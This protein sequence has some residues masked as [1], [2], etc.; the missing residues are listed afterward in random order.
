MQLRKQLF[1]S[2][3]HYHCYFCAQVDILTLIPITA[4]H[5]KHKLIII[6]LWLIRLFDKI[7]NN[8]I[9]NQER[10]KYAIVNSIKFSRHWYHTPT[11]ISSLLV[12]QVRAIDRAGE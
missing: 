10:F 12:L 3:L 1:N 8:L 11:P 6:W 2:P 7:N 9:I 4:S 5:F